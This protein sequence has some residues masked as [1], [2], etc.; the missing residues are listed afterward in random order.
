MYLLSMVD[1]PNRSVSI[2]WEG[3]VSIFWEG[4]LH[5]IEKRL[6]FNMYTSSEIQG[7]RTYHKDIE[8]EEKD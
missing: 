3:S 4:N 8:D 5:L 2:F 1:V 7:K 6:R